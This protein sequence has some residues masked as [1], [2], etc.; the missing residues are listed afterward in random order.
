MPEIF[1]VPISRNPYFTGREEV[2]ANLAAQLA[3]SGRAALGQVAP[4]QLPA[5]TRVAISGL[6]GIG[7]TQTVVEFAHRHRGDYRNVFFVRAETEAELLGGF[8]EVATL[9]EVADQE[10]DQMAMAQAARRWFESNGDWLLILD[11]ADTPGM[12]KNFLPAA[13]HGHILITSRAPSFAAQHI[14][15]QRLALPHEAESVAFL[16]HRTGRQTAGEAERQAAAELAGELGHLP[17]ALEQA[18]AYLVD[19]GTSFGA[20]L[21][22]FRK[23]GLEL[24]ERAEPE[25]GTGHPSVAVTWSLNFAEVERISPASADLLKAAPSWRRTR[26]RTSFFSKAAQSSHRRSPRFSCKRVFSHSTSWSR[27]CSGSLW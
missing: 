13:G 8:A 18:A 7:K 11:N 6:G 27:R 24:L 10:K 14:E 3:A 26:F 15:T 5:A 9:L 17:L 16:L 1:S 22:A 4:A 19:R 20:Y 25:G 2:L 23:K 21:E 12:L